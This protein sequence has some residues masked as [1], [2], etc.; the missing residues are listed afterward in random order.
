MRPQKLQEE[1]QEKQ[2]KFWQLMMVHHILP[3]NKLLISNYYKMKDPNKT[4]VPIE[5]KITRT[6]KSIEVK[7]LEIEE[8]KEDFN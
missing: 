6:L 2:L 7:R 1:E 3:I 5:F 4:Y 8:K